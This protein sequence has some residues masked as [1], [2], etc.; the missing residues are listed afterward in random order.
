MAAIRKF[1]FDTDFA[2]RLP[3]P[4]ANQAEEPA[5]PAPEAPP[6][7]VFSEE[8]VAIA[9]NEGFAAGKREGIVEAS[10]AVERQIAETLARIEGSLPDVFAAQ[11]KAAESLQHDGMTVIRALARKTLP[12]LAKDN[13]LGEIEHLAGVVLDRLRTEPRVVFKVNDGLTGALQEKLSALAGTKGYAGSV[14][15]LGDAGIAPGDCRIEWSQGGAERQA[16]AILDEMDRIIQRNS[17]GS[18]GADADATADA[19]VAGSGNVPADET[20]DGN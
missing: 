13:G 9:R 20:R 16:A 17:G 18:V 2:P 4:P 12:S 10:A 8:D 5:A 15:V 11:Q 3:A 19:A 1:L 14:A 7:P 6:P